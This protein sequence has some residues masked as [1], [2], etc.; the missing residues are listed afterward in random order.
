MPVFQKFIEQGIYP[1]LRDKDIIPV[2]DFMNDIVAGDR[3]IEE[4]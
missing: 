3:F 2:M 1:G 4:G